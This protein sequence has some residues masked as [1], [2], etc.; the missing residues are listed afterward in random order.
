MNAA[1][2]RE[3]VA[4][5]LGERAMRSGSV[6]YSGIDTLRPGPLYLMGYNPGG[7]PGQQSAQEQ[8][9]LGQ[10]QDRTNW[11]AYTQDCWLEHHSAEACLH[12][13]AGAQRIRPEAL[14]RH[15]RNIIAL[16]E[17]LGAT[18]ESIPSANAI[19]ARS[20]RAADLDDEAGWW[21]TCWAVHQ[22][23][24]GAVRPNL[25]ITLGKGFG[26]SAFSLLMRELQV[27]RSDVLETAGPR[28]A[29]HFRATIHLGKHQEPLTATVIGLPHPSYHS[30]GEAARHLVKAEIARAVQGTG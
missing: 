13:E 15:Q 26:R 20:K 9:I 23:M 18:P 6:L 10:I 8:S 16:A 5:R 24:L 27:D 2:L 11:S 30:A 22:V 1:E 7:D 25:V 3:T 29:R 21:K 17:V 14:T 4:T 12:R 28:S 19:F